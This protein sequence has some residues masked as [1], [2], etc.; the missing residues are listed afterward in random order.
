[1]QNLS[2]TDINQYRVKFDLI[3]F[4]VTD[5]SGSWDAIKFSKSKNYLR[6]DPHSQKLCQYIIE[7]SKRSIRRTNKMGA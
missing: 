1:M 5:E 2:E 4:S 7:R 6:L 3:K